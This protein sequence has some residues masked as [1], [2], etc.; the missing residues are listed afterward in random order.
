MNANDLLHLISTIIRTDIGKSRIQGSG[1]FYSRFL[2]GSKENPEYGKKGTEWR[3]VK[4]IWLVTNRHVIIP[5]VE[6]KE[7]PPTKLQ[8]HFRKYDKTE[9]LKWDPITLSIGEIESLA[10]FH[11]YNSVDVAVINITE[12]MLSRVKVCETFID[13]YLLSSQNFAGENNLDVHASSDVIIV[14]YP[15][16]YYDD[17]NLFPIVK[18]GIIASRWAVGFQ[19]NPYFLIDAKLFPGSSGSVVLSKPSNIFMQGNL[20][21]YSN[22]SRFAFLGIFSGEPKFRE[23]PVVIGD[24]TVTQSHGFNLGIVWYADLVEEIISQGVSLSQALKP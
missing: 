7:V 20:P 5:R 8:F 17:V 12:I 14:G 24:L 15:K 10:K 16:G 2:P 6:D 13:P 21:M 3:T 18:L 9:H 1:F 22:Q 23:D 19:G 11:P 4:D